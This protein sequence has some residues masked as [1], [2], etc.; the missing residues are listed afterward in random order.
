MNLLQLCLTIFLVHLIFNFL[1]DLLNLLLGNVEFSILELVG[2]NLKTIGAFISKITLLSN[3]DHLISENSLSLIINK[4]DVL[5]LNAILD[6]FLYFSLAHGSF[7]LRVHL[8]AHAVDHH[9]T[10]LGFN[11]VHD[12][13]TLSFGNL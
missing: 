4:L 10:E 6:V 11:N 8:H 13:S 1:L 7:H 12:A 3:L 5:R 2:V 9:H